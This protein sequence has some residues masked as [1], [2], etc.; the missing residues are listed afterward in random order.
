M[1]VLVGQL[2]LIS[3]QVQSRAGAPVLEA[4]TFGLFSQ[5]QLGA[6]R[7]FGGVG[8]TWD[9]YFGLRGAQRRTSA[10]ASS[11]PTRV[12]LQEQQALALRA[13]QL[14]ALLELRS[15]TSLP[16]VAAE[17]IAGNPNRGF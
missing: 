11:W 5:V 4:V 14:E 6:A 10:A 7:V 9:G 3:A 8:G 12:R 2:I 15:S 1:R 17:V 16:T 13:A